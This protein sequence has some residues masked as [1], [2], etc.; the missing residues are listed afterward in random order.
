MDIRSYKCT[1]ENR[2]AGTASLYTKFGWGARQRLTIGSYAIVSETSTAEEM[3][4]ESSN[5][6]DGQKKTRKE[7]EEG[8]EGEEGSVSNYSAYRNASNNNVLIS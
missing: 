3:G 1:R 7:G 6:T 2:R 4:R 8:E 5:K